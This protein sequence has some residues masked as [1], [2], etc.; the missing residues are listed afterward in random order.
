MAAKDER[1]DKNKI[2]E[3]GKP[4]Q[5][6]NT[7]RRRS[8]GVGCAGVNQFRYQNRSKGRHAEQRQIGERLVRLGD[9][10]SRAKGNMNI[11]LAAAT[12]GEKMVRFTV[13]VGRS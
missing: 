1:G 4:E 13:A 9:A 10:A 6:E 12:A 7:A 2:A 8:Y 11:A 5:N 3:L